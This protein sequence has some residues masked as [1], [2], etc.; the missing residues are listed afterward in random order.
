MPRITDRSFV[1]VPSH[2]TDIGKR[3]KRMADAQRKLERDWTAA[4][5]ED[6]ER[7]S[8]NAQEAGQKVVATIGRKAK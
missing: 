2:E 4:L 1:Y 3:F 7:N 6:A 8:T 5:K